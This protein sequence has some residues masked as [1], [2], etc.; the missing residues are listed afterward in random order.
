MLLKSPNITFNE[1]DVAE[2]GVLL[3]FELT[4][5]SL[6]FVLLFHSGRTNYKVQ[7]LYTL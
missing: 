6:S 1:Q 5:I 3:Y 4:R 2:L 7:K